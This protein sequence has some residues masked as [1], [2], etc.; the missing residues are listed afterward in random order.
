MMGYRDENDQNRT[1]SPLIKPLNSIII[2]S[3]DMNIEE[4]FYFALNHIQNH[5]KK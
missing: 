5:L 1:V 3:T 2:D 4:T